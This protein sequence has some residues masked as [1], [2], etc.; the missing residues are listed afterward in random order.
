MSSA[1]LNTN[2]NLNGCDSLSP[3]NK[4]LSSS[5]THPVKQNNGNNNNNTNN[6]NGGV[7]NSNGNV[8]NQNNTTMNGTIKKQHW[9]QKKHESCISSQSVDVMLVMAMD[10]QQNL[11]S[12]SNFFIEVKG[13]L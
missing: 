13:W 9:S 12:S 7:G 8:A 5:N 3:N 6:N 4:L 2:S 11:L 1:I 10:N